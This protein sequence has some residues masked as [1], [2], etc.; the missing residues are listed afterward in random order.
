MATATTDDPT[1]IGGNAEQQFDPNDEVGIKNISDTQRG[2]SK[3]DGSAILVNKGEGLIVKYKDYLK[4]KDSRTP[5]GDKVWK[6]V[7]K[8]EV[9]LPTV[10]QLKQVQDIS[11]AVDDTFVEGLKSIVNGDLDDVKAYLGTTASVPTLQ[12]LLPQIS[13]LPGIESEAAIKIRSLIVK[14]ITE[15]NK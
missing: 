5:N 10:Y 12:K 14:R 15:V 6:V 3:S 9:N 1:K 11:T 2:F 8:A 4:I 7:P 13:D